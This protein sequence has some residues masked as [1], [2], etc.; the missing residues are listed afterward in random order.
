[1]QN[2]ECDTRYQPVTEKTL[3]QENLQY[4][5]TGGVSAKNHHMGFLPAYLDT[6]TGNIYLSRFPDGRPAPVHLLSGLPRELF[7]HRKP[8]SSQASVK[9]SV[10]SG[11]LW[12][13]T[14][15][16]RAEAALATAAAQVH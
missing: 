8:S 11:F 5:G 6:E 9:Q 16:T 7:V 14:F 2:H 1:M 10:I 3:K 4:C 13:R 15:Y 12:E